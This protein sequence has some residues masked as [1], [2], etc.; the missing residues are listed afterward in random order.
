MKRQFVTAS[1]DPFASMMGYS[2]D[3]VMHIHHLCAQLMEEARDNLPEVEMEVTSYRID[4]TGKKLTLTGDMTYEGNNQWLTIELPLI[5]SVEE[6][7]FKAVVVE[8]LRQVKK[9]YGL[10]SFENTDLYN[11][12]STL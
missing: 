6:I 3:E 1:V 5:S 4:R 2:N 9:A 12:A 10:E 11:L 7:E 8:Y